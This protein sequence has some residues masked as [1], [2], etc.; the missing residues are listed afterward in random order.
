[1]TEEIQLPQSKNKMEN[2]NKQGQGQVKA[3]KGKQ[4]KV[5]G[6]KP[7]DQI[8]EAARVDMKVNK[9]IKSIKTGV[10]S[11]VDTAVKVGMSQLFNIQRSA[12][13]LFP[14]CV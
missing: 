12:K 14:G 3:P 1:M 5:K 6:E 4:S 10:K 8:F 7:K 2:G 11:G 13:F 9:F